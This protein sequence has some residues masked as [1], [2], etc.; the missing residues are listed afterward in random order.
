MHELCINFKKSY[1]LDRREVLY[2]NLILFGINMKQVTLIKM[3]LIETSDRI[4]VGN[5]LSDLFFIKNGFKQG[6]ALL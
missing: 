1:D 6:N 3:C 4:G 5:R 2:N